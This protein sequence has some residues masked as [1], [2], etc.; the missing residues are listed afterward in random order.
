MLRQ[1]MIISMKGYEPPKYTC[2]KKKRNCLTF[3][4]YPVPYQHIPCG[5]PVCIRCYTRSG[6]WMAQGYIGHVDIG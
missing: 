1:V 3:V 5:C 4:Q 6:S 2:V